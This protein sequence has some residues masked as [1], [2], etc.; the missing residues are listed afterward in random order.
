M[1][2]PPPGNQTRPMCGL[3]KR[4][5]PTR[6]LDAPPIA[7]CAVHPAARASRLRFS[8]RLTPAL[9]GSRRTHDPWSMKLPTPSASVFRREIKLPP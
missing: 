8:P 4:L 1:A 6:D 5:E 7:R 3:P 9:R 2:F